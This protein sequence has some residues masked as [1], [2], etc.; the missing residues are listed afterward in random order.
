MQPIFIPINFYTLL[1]LLTHTK[2]MYPALDP[3]PRY[4][5]KLFEIF[6]CTPYPPNTPKSLLSYIQSDA[7]GQ[8]HGC[9]KLLEIYENLG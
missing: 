2:Y 3:P 8:T 6:S 9:Q 1:T 7:N 4:L 5:H